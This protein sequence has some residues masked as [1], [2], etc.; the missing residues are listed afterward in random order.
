MLMCRKRAE[1]SNV[2][3]GIEHGRQLPKA[4]KSAH[5]RKLTLSRRGK[6]REYAPPEV[7]LIFLL[8]AQSR[9][10]SV[11]VLGAHFIVV[12]QFVT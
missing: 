9:G 5:A 2:G 10:G 6:G 8:I 1:T 4:A 12:G 11:C 3:F 7:E